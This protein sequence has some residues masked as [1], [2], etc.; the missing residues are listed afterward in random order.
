VQE[1]SPAR[2]M[3]NRRAMTEDKLMEA[4]R[5]RAAGDARA[6]REKYPHE[7][8]NERWLDNSY[9][10][11]LPLAKDEAGFDPGTGPHPHLFD[12]YRGEVTRVLG[13]G[14]P[15]EAAE[16]ERGGLEQQPTRGEG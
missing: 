10:A 4:L 7:T 8:P 15:R 5:A 6:F 2:D 1:G 12:L 11:A 13:S 3:Q 9:T 14:A 16:S